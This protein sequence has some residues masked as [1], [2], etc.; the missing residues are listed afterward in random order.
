LIFIFISEDGAG[1]GL[2]DPRPE[3]ID[4]TIVTDLPI[5]KLLAVFP[6]P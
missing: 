6:N 1:G 4:A 2:I 5:G 3:V